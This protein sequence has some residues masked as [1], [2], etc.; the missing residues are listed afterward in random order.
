VS[1]IKQFWM[2]IASG[3]ATSGELQMASDMLSIAQK[4]DNFVLH[5]T[6]MLRS[7]EHTR[8]SFW[9]RVLTSNQVFRFLRVCAIVSLRFSFVDS[10]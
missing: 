8:F 1:A 6:M 5:S 7:L 2:R 4:P 3:G 9:T 10:S